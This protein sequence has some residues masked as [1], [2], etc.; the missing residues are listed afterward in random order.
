VNAGLLVEQLYST[1]PGGIGSYI[2]ALCRLLPQQAAA[3]QS[4]VVAISAFH[5]RPRPLGLGVRTIPLPSR[6]LLA[7]WQ[8]ARWPPVSS[9]VRDLGVMLAPSLALPAPGRAPLV[10]FCAD[11]AFLRLPHAYT[12]WG[13]WFHA[14]GLELARREA[15]LVLTC[16]ETTA[17]DLVDLGGIDRDRIRVIPLGA[18]PPLVSDPREALERRRRLGVADLPYFL[19]VG[20]RQPRKNLAGVL[21]AARHLADLPHHLVLAGPRGWVLP[22]LHQDVARLGLSGRAHLLGWVPP[23]DLSALYEGA[24]ALCFPSLYEGFGLPV[25]EAMAHGTPVVT[26]TVSSLPEVAGGAAMLVD[27][28]DPGAIASALRQLADD[29]GLRE[30]KAAAGLCR[31]ALFT[32]DASVRATWEALKEVAR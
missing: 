27:P 32:W 18:D 19:W 22:E 29:E 1:A 12:S 28:N 7:S 30:E 25:I 5:R 11:V 14:R 3:D 20:T 10:V 8:V 13:R 24:T 15:A 6:A 31:A 21:E 2:E 16:G 4:E 17:G 9:L 23:E 26:S